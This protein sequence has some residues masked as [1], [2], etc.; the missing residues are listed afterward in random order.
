M[1]TLLALLSVLALAGSVGALT[2]KQAWVPAVLFII[3]LVL[4][5]LTVVSSLK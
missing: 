5:G 2:G 1:I 3:S 4:V